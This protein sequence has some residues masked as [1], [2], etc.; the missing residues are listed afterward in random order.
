MIRHDSITCKSCQG[1]RLNKG[2]ATD[3]KDMLLCMPQLQRAWYHLSTESA[4]VC[5]T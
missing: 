3:E 4:V 5:H 2:S 1:T